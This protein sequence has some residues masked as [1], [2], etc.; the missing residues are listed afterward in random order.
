MEFSFTLDDL[1]AFLSTRRDDEVVGYCVE[2]SACLIAQAVRAKYAGQVWASVDGFDI[3][4]SPVGVR[5][6]LS[7]VLD[8]V[9]AAFDAWT[10]KRAH[11]PVT[12]AEFLWAWQQ[13]LAFHEQFGEEAAQQARGWQAAFEGCGEEVGGR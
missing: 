2:A 9:V 13:Y 6:P 12:K 1:R 3:V 11:E 7:P 4:L 10:E 8:A 5:L